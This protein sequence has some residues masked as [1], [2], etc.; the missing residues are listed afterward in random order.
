M[1]EHTLSIRRESRLVYGIG[2]HER[3]QGQAH[4]QRSRI[5][6]PIAGVQLSEAYTCGRKSLEKMLDTVTAP[7]LVVRFVLLVVRSV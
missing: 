7:R 4:L 2:C 5:I 6:L 1:A 3:R